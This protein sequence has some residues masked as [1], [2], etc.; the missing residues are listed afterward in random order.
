MATGLPSLATAVNQAIQVHQH[1]AKVQHTAWAASSILDRVVQGMPI[2][3]AMLQV[4]R[5]RRR[6]HH[7]IH[8]A[9]GCPQQPRR[10]A[11]PMCETLA[12]GG[13]ANG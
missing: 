5:A 13:L 11:S 9:C 12:C 4:R 8:H 6:R 2:R 7:T 1:G 10:H 3:E